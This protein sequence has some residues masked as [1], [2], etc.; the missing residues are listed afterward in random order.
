MSET[1]RYEYAHLFSAGEYGW[2]LS[3]YNRSEEQIDIIQGKWE[4]PIVALNKLDQ[5]GW[6]VITAY[7]VPV[8]KDVED[9]ELPSEEYLLRRKL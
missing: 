1:V 6:E 3:V 8:P 7:Y 9:E 5:E 4:T 2:E